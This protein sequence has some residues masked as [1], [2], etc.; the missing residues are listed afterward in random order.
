MELKIYNQKGELKLAVNTEASSTWNMELMAENAVSATFIHPFFVTLDV[1]DY[2]MFEGVKFSMNRE[3]KPKQ[4]STQEYSY[5]VKFYGPEHDAQRVM[6]LNLADG[7]YEPQFFLDD[8]PRVH[9]EKWIENMNRIYG[10][11]VWSIGEVVDK[12]GKNIEYNNVT[13]WDALASI[14]ETFETEWWTDG[15][16]INFCRCERGDQVSLGY[17]QG[18]TS[19]TQSENDSDVQFFTRLIPLGSTKNIDR[20]RYGYT[21]LQLPDKSKYVDRNT[22]YGLYEHVEE[23]AFAEIYPHYLGTVTYV[24]SEVKTD[25]EDKKYTVYYFHDEGMQ[26]DPNESEIGGL[27]K[28]ISFQPGS[29]L[30]GRGNSENGVSWFDAKYDSEKLEWEI[31]NVYPSDTE[32]IQ[33]PGGNIIPRAG[34]QYIPWNFS[35]PKSYEQEAELAYAAAVNSFLEKYSED[36]SKYGGDTDYIYVDENKIPLQLGQRVRL[37]NDK[38]F[39]VTDGCFDTRMTKVV[40]KL[41]N[42]SMASIECTNQVGKGWKRVIEQ[43]L[44]NLQYI[45][46]SSTSGGFNN[47]GSSSGTAISSDLLQRDIQV[48]SNDVGYLKTG[49]VVLAGQTWEKILRSM[50]Y[51]QLGADLRSNISTSNDVEFGSKKGYI[52]YTT[53]RNG[54]GAMKEA[55]YDGKKENKL[56]FSKENAGKQEAVRQLSGMYTENET[57]KA[58]VVFEASAGGSLPEK[59]LTNT[60][61]VNVRRKWFA[62]VVDSVPTTSAQ[63]RA[64]SSNGLYMGANTYS[65]SVGIWRTMVICIPSGSISNVT[66]EGIQGNYLESSGVFRAMKSIS[67]EGVNN[68]TAINYDMYVFQ[69]DIESD[70]ANFKFKTE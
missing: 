48:N 63:V 50:L 32:D 10:R 59:E 18:L 29:D 35:L 2:V 33:I 56:T 44:A 57:Y 21:R 20:N 22:Q 4:V 19:L 61:S 65:F 43:S 25:D 17:Q 27:E 51:K 30:A 8:A 7:Q 67:V 1:N 46:G 15:F 39:P 66:K 55:Y 54:Q 60:I 70:A 5:T 69:V 28:R 45:V 9:L 68:S 52:T 6:F 3:Y 34:D 16:V 31:T 38:C 53:T 37:L 14:S 36:F 64:L 26:F 47:G 40:R 11:K 23:S 58:T 62:G 12:P 42:L 49:D 13:C 41:D 24:R